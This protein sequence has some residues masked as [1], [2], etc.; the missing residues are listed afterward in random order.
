MEPLFSPLT[1]RS[2]I[3]SVRGCSVRSSLAIA[4]HLGHGYSHEQVLDAYLNVVY[5]GEHSYGVDRASRHYFAR[6]A[7]RLSLAQASLL[8][9]LI[10]AP[11][12][13]D[14]ATNA[15]GARQRQIDV[16]RSM[17]RN[18]FA[19]TAEAESALSRPLRLA[20]GTTLPLLGGRVPLAPGAPFDWAELAFAMVLLGLALASF[21][22]AQTLAPTP[23]ARPLLL[24]A[25][26]LILLLSAI[27]TAGHS[28]QVV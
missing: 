2:F 9:G 3:R 24:Q 18:G 25:A 28:I 22:A 16:L 13:D 26:A 6:P 27:W 17:V 20:T 23:A 4:F 7:A 14:P 5:L 11:S 10:Q 1:R 12:R 8:A 15:R 19:T 21:R